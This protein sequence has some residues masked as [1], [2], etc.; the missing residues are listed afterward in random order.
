M[1]PTSSPCQ[2]YV[3]TPP[4]LVPEAFAP[5]MIRAL[6][7]GP[8][9]SFQLRLEGAD[10]DQWRAAIEKLMPIAQERDVAFIINNKVELV[11]EM[12]TD[13]VHLGIQDM[14]IKE[15]RALLG[16]DKIIGASCLDSK[17]LAMTAAESGAD[18]VSFG[19]FFTTRSPYYPKE[20]YAPKYMVSPNIL[21][22]WSAIMEVPCVAAGGIKPSNCHDLV[23]AG[24]DFICASSS[25]WDYPGGGA[26][27]IRDFHEAMNQVARKAG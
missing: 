11:K 26:A 18:Y 9:A 25:I 8:V 27:A 5:H 15:A 4:K 24:A 21:S 7:A 10:I 22:W 2:L 20:K 23:K 14:S 6:E 19:P 1:E 3:I 16:P 17:H 13:G 12:E